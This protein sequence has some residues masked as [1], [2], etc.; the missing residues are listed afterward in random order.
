MVGAGVADR[1]PERLA[2]LAY[3]DSVV[4][5]DG[6]SLYDAASDDGS[7]R[8]AY[9]DR[10]RAAGTPGF[11]PFRTEGIEGRVPDVTDRAWMLA[12]IVAHPIATFEQPI[13][14]RNPAAARLPR[15]YILCT[16]GWD[17]S[18]PEPTFVARARFDPDWRFL[19]LAAN[20][21]APISAPRATAD[22]LRALV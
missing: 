19:E 14:L 12:R 5:E 17:P 8:A 10:I 18:E 20:H 21:F 6:Q 1:A 3:L 15:A 11:L 9:Q 16:E 2:R 7:M 22:A 13:R 4:P